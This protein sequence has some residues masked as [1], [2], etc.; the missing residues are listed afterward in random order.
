[1][2]KLLFLALF[3]GANTIAIAQDTYY[4]LAVKGKILNK[5]TNQYLKARQKIRSSDKVIFKDKNAK[6]LIYSRGKGR[7]NL[8]LNPQN[9]KSPNELVVLVKK[10]IFSQQMRAFTRGQRIVSLLGLQKFIEQGKP[11]FAILNDRLELEFTPPMM[12]QVV[13]ELGEG[14]FFIRYQYEGKT[15]NIGLTLK[16]QKLIFTKES[17]FKTKEGKWLDPSKASDMHLAFYRQKKQVINGVTLP[18]GAFNL[19]ENETKLMFNPVFLTTQ[20]AKDKG[21]FALAKMLKNQPI[22]GTTEQIQDD[23][24]EAL[25]EFLASIYGGA[26]SDNVETWYKQN[27]K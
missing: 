20:E 11:Q 18:K 12:G 23:I 17:L 3:I 13:G 21:L 9:K 14:I 5:K 19:G 15:R 4:I 26:G 2:R 6:A 1:M 24:N 27:F 22:K 25:A 10:S 16:D 7:F 8:T